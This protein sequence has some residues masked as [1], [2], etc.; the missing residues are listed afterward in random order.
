MKNKA[1]QVTC[2]GKFTAPSFIDYSGVSS[3][4]GTTPGVAHLVSLTADT[5]KMHNFIDAINTL[6]AAAQ[7]HP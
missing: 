2:R 3:I 1:R 7:T 4:T 6:P 5:D